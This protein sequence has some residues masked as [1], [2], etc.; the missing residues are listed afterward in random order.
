LWALSAKR[1]K[2]KDWTAINNTRLKTQFLENLGL[3]MKIKIK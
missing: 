3:K 2:Y 1:T